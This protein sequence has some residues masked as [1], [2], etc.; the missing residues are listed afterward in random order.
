MLRTGLIFLF[1]GIWIWMDKITRHTEKGLF[2]AFVQIPQIVTPLLLVPEI[3]Q[4]ANYHIDTV[5]G[6][7][8]ILAAG[9][10]IFFCLKREASLREE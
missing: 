8:I 7:A 4:T 5:V 2:I 9:L 1:S 6:I 10:F 3:T